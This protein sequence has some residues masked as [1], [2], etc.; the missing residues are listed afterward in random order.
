MPCLENVVGAFASLGKAGNPTSLPDLGK[1]FLAPCKELV[2]IGLMSHVPYQG[3][4]GRIEDPVQ[5]DSE[6][7]DTEVGGEMASILTHRVDD[8]ASHFLGESPQFFHRK[9]LYILW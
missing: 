2:G 7:Y 8:E 1:T 3:V 4:L 5:S 9:L 6:F